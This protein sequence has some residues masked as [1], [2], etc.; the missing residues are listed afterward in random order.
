METEERKDEARMIGGHTSFCPLFL[1]LWPLEEIHLF[2]ASSQWGQI[3]LC[4]S[5]RH[6]SAKDLPGGA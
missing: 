6:F 5:H 2:K 3:H 4:S 1:V